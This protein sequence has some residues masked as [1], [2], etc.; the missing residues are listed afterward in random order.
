MNKNL[1]NTTGVHF[2]SSRII[3]SIFP[4]PGPCAYVRTYVRTR[5]G[6]RD[7]GAAR[8]GGKVRE[9]GRGTGGERREKKK[10]GG[11]E[12]KKKKNQ[13]IIDVHART[14]LYAF[15]YTLPR[16]LR[17][18]FRDACKLSLKWPK[19]RSKFLLECSRRLYHNLLP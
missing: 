7:R 3:E 16:V 4:P 12:G 8:K 11:E 15:R 13:R 10:G 14:T 19:L 6:E 18:V 17:L 2:V 5:Q 1:H 9:E